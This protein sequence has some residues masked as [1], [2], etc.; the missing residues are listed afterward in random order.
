MPCTQGYYCPGSKL[1][2]AD[3]LASRRECTPN[4]ARTT[5]SAVAKSAKECVTRPG[6][7]PSGECGIGFYNP[8][9][10]TRACTRCPGGLTTATATAKSPAECVAPKGSYYLRGK[11]LPCAQGT[12]KD[13]E[14]NADCQKCPDGTTTTVGAVGKT[15]ASECNRE[16][17]PDAL[18]AVLVFLLPLCLLF[19]FLNTSLP[20]FSF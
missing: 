7:G 9:G 3:S 5:L 17:A 16:F 18:L 1:T 15:Q 6:Y 20:A 14:G 12:Y 8:G 11:A 4:I 19:A 2:R 13:F 10:N